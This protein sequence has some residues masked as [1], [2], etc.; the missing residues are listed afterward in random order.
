MT[1]R[2][3]SVLSIPVTDQDRAKAFYVDV[4]GFEL[5]NDD[6]MGPGQRWVQVRPPGA[7]TSITLVTWFEQ[8]PAGS[9]T[10][11]VLNTDDVVADHR[12]LTAKGVVFEAEPRDDVWGVWTS[13][14][15][16]DRNGWVLAETKT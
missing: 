4:L 1:I 9:V 16:P 14:T 11:L 6:P 2:N 8:M 3:V 5:M 13:F 10:G 12:A 7:E 15:D